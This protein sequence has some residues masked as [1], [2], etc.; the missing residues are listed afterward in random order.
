MKKVCDSC[1]KPLTNSVWKEGIWFC[2]NKKCGHYGLGI[3]EG[4]KGVDKI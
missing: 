4:E 2:T 1:G 3:N